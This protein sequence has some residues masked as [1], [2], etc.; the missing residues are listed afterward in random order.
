MPLTLNAHAMIWTKV[1]CKVKSWFCLDVLS[2]KKWRL[3]RGGRLII[4]AG[5]VPM[6]WHQTHGNHGNHVFDLFLI[7]FCS[8]HYYKPVLPD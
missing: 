8:S 3:L 4:M 7:S 1:L 5:M 2:T 6:E